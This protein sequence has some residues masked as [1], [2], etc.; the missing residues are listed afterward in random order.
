[1]ISNTLPSNNRWFLL[2]DQYHESDRLVRNIER[3]RFTMALII[4]S[5]NCWYP[6]CVFQNYDYHLTYFCRI[7]DRYQHLFYRNIISNKCHFSHTGERCYI[8]F[9]AINGVVFC[10]K[11]VQCPLILPVLI[12]H[13]RTYLP[14]V[15]HKILKL[16]GIG[17]HQKTSIWFCNK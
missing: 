2:L 8:C 5:Y 12:T 1:M 7:A 9:S 3:L 16:F 15:D 14:F 10:F 11:T 6:F 13:I 17:A 4:F